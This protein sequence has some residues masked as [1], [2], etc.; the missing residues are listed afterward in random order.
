MSKS[1]RIHKETYPYC[2]PFT[3]EMPPSKAARFV[4]ETFSKQERG[5]RTIVDAGCGAG[6]D[7]LFLLSEGFRVIAVDISE[8]NL[9][10]VS[11]RI[12]QAQISSGMFTAYAADMI[13]R[14]PIEDATVD[15]VLDVWVLG[16]VILPHDGRKGA[17]QYLMEVHR[18]L[19]P[20]GLFVLQFETIKPR[21]SSDKTREY[22]ANLMKGY[23]SITT[24]E[25]IGVDYVRYVD[26]PYKDKL[27]SAVFAVA[28]KQ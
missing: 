2:H 21:R 23:F 19:K 1:A 24:S 27:N 17:R 25:T 15:A 6:Q 26:I 5:Q 7:T 3:K 4:M 18:I 11:R 20:G 10:I 12:S 22:L 16:S 13:E 8:D 9:D 14:I 28:C